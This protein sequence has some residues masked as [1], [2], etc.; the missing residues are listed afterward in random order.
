M[1]SLKLIVEDEDVVEKINS[2]LSPQ[3]RVWGI[4]RTTSSFSSYMACDSRRYEYLIPTHSFLP[5]HPNSWLAK[6]LS[7]IA[8]ENGDRKAYDERQS[9]VAGFW[10]TVEKEQIQPILD[11]LED[12]IKDEILKALYEVDLDRNSPHYDTEEVKQQLFEAEDADFQVDET[13]DEQLPPNA[14]SIHKTDDAID[15]VDGEQQVHSEISAKIGQELNGAKGGTEM[16]DTNESLIE[17]EAEP[18]ASGKD[19]T[20]ENVPASVI[21]KR[22]IDAALRTLRRTYQI[23]KRTYRIDPARLARIQPLLNEFL[24]TNNFHNYTIQKSFED[25]SA[26]RHI[27]SFVVHSDPIVINGT[28]W[29]SL[30]IHGQSFM[31]HQIRKMVAMLALVVRCG[32][33]PARIRQT[34]ANVDVSIPKAPALGLLLERPVF[35]TYNSGPAAKFSRDPIDF[36]KHEVAIEAFK[37][38]EIYERQFLEEEEGNQFH[39]FFAHTDNLRDPQL[40]YLSSGGFEAMKRETGKIEEGKARKVTGKVEG[41][42]DGDGVGGSISVGSEAHA[43]G[44]TSTDAIQET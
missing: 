2:H 6:K 20:D 24:G 5:P 3:I 39:Q 43:D 36:A 19:T 41:P 12:D 32:C 26:Q 40:L 38:R 29:L 37:R 23:A 28:E 16:K 15:V 10:N 27:K 31:M 42:T 21:R 13:I 7:E 18:T 1:I 8:D 44:V 14:S 11:G 4:Q 33:D 9:E 35:E 25:R 17:S 34:F 30:K 22:R